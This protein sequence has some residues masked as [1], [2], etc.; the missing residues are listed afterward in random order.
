MAP[1][2]AP[3]P[4]DPVL[5]SAC[6][7]PIGRIRGALAGVRPD[8]LLALVFREAL[9]RAG[10]PGERVD[11]AFAGCANQ[12]GEDNRNVARMAVLLAGLPESVPAVTLNRLCASGL[13]AVV[14]AAR[15]IRVGDAAVCLAGGT[16]S[17]S[18]APF[19]L[20][21]AD[22][23][24]PIGAPA[25]FDTS[26]GW[27]FPNPRLEA[28]FPLEQ[29]GETAENLVEEHGIS[30]ADQDAF[31]LRSH[32]KA[33]AAQASGLFDEEIVKVE[34]PQRKGP[35]LVVDKDEGPRADTTLEKLASLKPAFRKDGTVT[36]GNSS[37]LNDGAAALVVTSRAYAE[38]HGLLIRGVVRGAASAGVS[39][40]VMGI[41]PVPATKKLMERCGFTAAD[42]D[43]VELNEAFASQSLAVLRALGLPEEKVNLHG[44][45]IALGHPL[46][47]SGARVLTTLL[48]VLE[49]TSGRLGLATLC[50]GVG[51]GLAVL[52]ERP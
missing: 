47:C 32:E 5:V 31:A 19:A 30:R 17:M 12:A 38:E 1:R 51:Q 9:A 44:G 48:S 34:F 33:L 49:R 22:Q 8:D 2:F 29:M 18:R 46:G 23:A 10:V 21:K 42:L 7:T 11:E 20:Q 4:T 52:V 45:A 6:R 35:A 39:P 40:R 43:A 26:L 3:S 27:R 14:Q 15:A 41:G 24:F 16:E 25:I 28:I 36:A 50:V 37:T 13:E